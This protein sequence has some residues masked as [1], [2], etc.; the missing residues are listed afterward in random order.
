MNIDKSLL[1]IKLLVLGKEE[2]LHGLKNIEEITDLI[3]IRTRQ[4]AKRK[5]LGLG[6]IWP[7]GKSFILKIFQ[8]F[9][10]KF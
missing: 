7:L 8:F 1:Q 2:Y 5:T 10:K 6:A 9:L 3:N 4:Y